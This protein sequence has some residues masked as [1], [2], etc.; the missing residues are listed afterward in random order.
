MA[1]FNEPL[2]FSARSVKK[3]RIK[4]FQGTYRGNNQSLCETDP[5]PDGRQHAFQQHSCF[6]P[7]IQGTPRTEQR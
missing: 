2:P 1:I 3:I 6:L 5:A 7:F 4:D